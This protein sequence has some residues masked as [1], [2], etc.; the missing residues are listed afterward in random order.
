MTYQDDPSFFIYVH[1]P[2]A[3]RNLSTLQNWFN[4]NHQ[5]KFRL[6]N[7]D[8]VH[9]AQMNLEQLETLYPGVKTFSIVMNPWAL[10]FLAYRTLWAKEQAEP[11]V[12]T[13]DVDISSFENFIK[14]MTTPSDN[15]LWYSG[16]PNQIDW[17][18]FTLPNGDV[19]EADYIFRE[20]FLAEDF[21]VIQNFFETDA[22][23]ENI[24]PLP[25][26]KSRYTE[27]TKDI[28]AQ[29][30]ARDIARFGYTF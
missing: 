26:Y 14:G 1:I 27:E 20:E 6:I 30:F 11:G 12:Y 19:Q 28:V 13:K 23:L 10:C 9:D 25:D 21:S 2:F 15:G 29:A 4:N 17:L 8:E 7:D 24:H 5:A 16:V 3:E 22:P 18:K